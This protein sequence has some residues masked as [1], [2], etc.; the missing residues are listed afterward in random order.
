MFGFMSVLLALYFYAWGWGF[1]TI[2]IIDLIS[3]TGSVTTN[4]NATGDANPGLPVPS[5]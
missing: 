3:G 4:V 5:L 1:P 2:P